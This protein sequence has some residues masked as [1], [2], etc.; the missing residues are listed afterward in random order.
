MTE[1]SLFVSAKASVAQVQAAV[2]KLGLPGGVDDVAVEPCTPRLNHDVAVDMRGPEADEVA[3]RYAVQLAHEL[4][5]SV[6]VDEQLYAAIE[7]R[8]TT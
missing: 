6:F 2:S 3:P 7:P 1:A 8:L 5:V 4:G